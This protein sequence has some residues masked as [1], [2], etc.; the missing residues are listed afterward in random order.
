M[1]A[2]RRREAWAPSTPNQTSSKC[3]VWNF[4]CGITIIRII[5][6]CMSQAHRWKLTAGCDNGSTD[7]QQKSII[8]HAP[9]A[10]LPS[11]PPDTSE[12]LLLQRWML[13][14]LSPPWSYQHACRHASLVRRALTLARATL[15]YFGCHVELLGRFDASA[16]IPPGTS[17]LCG[18]KSCLFAR[19]VHSSFLH[20]E[21][22]HYC[23]AGFTRIL[24]Q[25]RAR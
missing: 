17:R 13:M 21:N 10:P 2:A 1:E 14:P 18:V 9:L 11:Q 25:G 8:E 15:G 3:L 24:A 7:D 4:V 5:P 22:V 12:V 20:E 19:L 16:S 23:A 6:A